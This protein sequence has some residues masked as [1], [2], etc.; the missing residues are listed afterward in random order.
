MIR[1]SIQ[2]T[3]LLAIS[4]CAFITPA[5]ARHS[6]EEATRLTQNANYNAVTGFWNVNLTRTV[7][8]I[9]RDLKKIMPQIS[10]L[11]VGEKPSNGRNLTLIYR[12]EDD[13][14]IT[15]KIKAKR[16]LTTLGIKSGLFGDK[17]DAKE[18]FVQIFTRM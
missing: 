1:K 10:H 7:E 13:Q 9:A 14:K 2:L 15:I 17:E 11:M 16:D 18:L 5:H 4:A 8:E 3:L 6:V 12:D